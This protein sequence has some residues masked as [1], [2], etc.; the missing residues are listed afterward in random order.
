MTSAVLKQLPVVH[1]GRRAV[2]RMSGA[3]AIDVL[4]NACTND[5]AV[6][7]ETGNPMFAAV[8]SSKGRTHF[9]MI[10]YPGAS[11]Q[12]L[13]LEVDAAVADRVVRLFSKPKP[14]KG[15]DV[16]VDHSIRVVAS[17]CG[18]FDGSATVSSL[19][20]AVTEAGGAMVACGTDA[21]LAAFGVRGLAQPSRT[22][23][24]TGWLSHL[25]ALE[26]LYDV[27]RTLAGLPERQTE[28]SGAVPLEW[29]LEQLGGVSF[30]KGCYLGQ[31]LVARAHFRGV[32][33]KRMVPVLLGAGAAGVCAA[34][35]RPASAS[36]LPELPGLALQ[37]PLAEAA[38][39]AGVGVA[40]SGSQ[41]AVAAAGAVAASLSTSEERLAISTAGAV[42]AGL[43]R[44]GG[45]LVAVVP[46]SNV[47]LAIMRL[48][49]LMP[50]MAAAGS[51]SVTDSEARYVLKDIRTEAFPE[52][53]PVTPVVPPFWSAV[54]A[55]QAAAQGRIG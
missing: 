19:H 15:V 39:A 5:V 7:L 25:D 21:R 18:A 31:E 30:S 29:N 32:L 20:R 27:A 36:V 24:T 9:E 48:A 14:R 40:A 43:G 16:A 41:G 53:V 17:V 11:G 28:V 12:D 55:S 42:E 44:G 3:R 1:L 47:G 13:L 54:E 38:A 45:R 33:R 6:M 37:G 22:D 26:P 34:P 4:N 50:Q 8:L 23:L 35:S 10:V 2:V 49:P 46:G 52:G 51:A